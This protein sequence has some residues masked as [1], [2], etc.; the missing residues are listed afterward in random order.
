MRSHGLFLWLVVG[1]LGTSAA[2]QVPAREAAEKPAS[3]AA[4]SRPCASRPANP[5]PKDKAKSKAATGEKESSST[6]LEGK[7]SAVDLQE[8][9]QSYVREQ[10]WRIRGEKIG[11]DGWTFSRFLDKDELVQFVNE[12][13]LAGRVKWV[14]GKALVHVATHELDGGFTRVEISAR[15]QGGGQSVDR[16]APPRDSWSLDSNGI[17]EKILIAALDEHLKSMHSSPSANPDSHR[18]LRAAQLSSEILLP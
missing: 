4:P 10:G 16:F 7:G 3:E 6:C 18:Y 1:L 13:L 5:S 2:A 17:L 15:F 14:D 8:F 12:G 9:F 11:E